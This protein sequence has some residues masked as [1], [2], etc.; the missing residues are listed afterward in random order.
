MWRVHSGVLF[1][2]YPPT[3]LIFISMISS[4]SMSCSDYDGRQRF[5]H[6][7]VFDE[8]DILFILNY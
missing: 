2:R 7:P 1:G 3:T 5:D 4:T 6:S 8:R